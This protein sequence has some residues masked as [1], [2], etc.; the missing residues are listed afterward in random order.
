MAKLAHNPEYDIAMDGQAFGEIEGPGK[1]SYLNVHF[2]TGPDHRGKPSHCGNAGKQ[3]LGIEFAHLIL[4]W[5]EQCSFAWFHTLAGPLIC[6]QT[7]SSLN[8]RA[9]RK[10][11]ISPGNKWS[12]LSKS[13]FPLSEME[14]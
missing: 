12:T 5:H 7:T 6:L 11:L 14:Y 4:N 13:N 3:E 9:Q 8:A 10:T 2:A 1:S